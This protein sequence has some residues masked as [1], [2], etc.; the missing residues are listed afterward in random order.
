VFQE[1]ADRLMDRWCV[2]D[3]IIVQHQQ[4]ILR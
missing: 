2:D 4:E 1:K 3:V